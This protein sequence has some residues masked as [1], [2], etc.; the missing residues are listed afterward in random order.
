MAQHFSKQHN[1]KTKSIHLSVALMGSVS[2]GTIQSV[3]DIVTLPMK[4]LKK[5][6]DSDILVDKTGECDV[7]CVVLTR[8]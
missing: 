6:Q 7:I 8:F 5:L 3:F 4:E 2:G 1:V